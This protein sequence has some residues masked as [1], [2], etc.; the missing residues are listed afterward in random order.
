MSVST[1]QV[2]CI[3]EVLFDYLADQLGRNLEDVENWT[4]YPGGAP[5]NIACALT[6]LGTPA[7]FLGCVGQDANGIE[8]TALLESLGINLEGLQQHPTA[9]TR[10]VYV[11]RTV[12]GERTFAGFGTY[13]TTTFADTQ[14]SGAKLPESLFLGAQVLVTGT[15]GM[16]YPESGA[17]IRRAVEFAQMHGLQVFVD[18]NW[19]PVFWTNQTQAKPLI[20]ELLN[21]AN[22]IKVSDEEAEWYFGNTDPQSIQVQYPQVKGVLVTAGER[23]CRYWLQGTTG[24]IPAFGVTVV[25]TTGAGDAFTAGLLHQI[26]TQPD[27]ELSN[28][29]VAAQVVR[30]ASAVGALTTTQAGAIAAQPTADTVDIFLHHSPLSNC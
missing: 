30:Y 12:Q 13:D 28:P 25:D 26:C 29:T 8:L 24:E 27:L 11:T 21:Q 19:R 7:A 1:P 6:R 10:I 17:A 16:A 15:L 18:L 5:A 9:P 3:G 14:L 2:I 22:W 20:A 4:A 23:G